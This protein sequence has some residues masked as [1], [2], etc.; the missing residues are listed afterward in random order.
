MDFCP[1]GELFYNMTKRAK[2]S[3]SEAKFIFCEA[4]LGL[5]YLHE[6]NILYRDLKVNSEFIISLRMYFW[7][8]M[9]TSNSLISVSLKN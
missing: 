9:D 6:H 5:E 3:E 4:F 1:G 2:F 7:I 8:W